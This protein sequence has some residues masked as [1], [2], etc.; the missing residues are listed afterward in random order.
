M[1]ARTPIAREAVIECP[2][3]VHT[4]AGRGRARTLPPALMIRCISRRRCGLWSTVTSAAVSCPAARPPS[5]ARE[6][7][8]HAK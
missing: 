6:M 4:R 3:S 5:T 7:P 8:T 1:K 2:L